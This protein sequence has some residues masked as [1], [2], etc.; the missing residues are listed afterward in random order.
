MTNDLPEIVL[1]DTDVFSYLMEPGDLRGLPYLRHVEQRT[2]ALSFI[3]VGE[4]LFGALWRAWGKRRIGDLQ[5]RLDAAFI[6]PLDHETSVEYAR[7][8]TQLRKGGQILADNDLWIAAL[9]VRH[10]V[11]LVSNNRAHFNRVPGLVLISEAPR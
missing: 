2:A 7:L 4:L 5:R 6:L 1:L 9:A 3:T 11:P 8:K 10:S